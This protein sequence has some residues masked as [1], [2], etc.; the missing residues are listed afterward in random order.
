MTKEIGSFLARRFRDV[1]EESN[2]SKRLAE[3]N[4]ISTEEI[5][6]IEQLL[7]KV[8]QKN[9]DLTSELMKFLGVEE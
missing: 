4:K 8:D 5:T 6:A 9:F 7:R 1:C 2:K 3:Y